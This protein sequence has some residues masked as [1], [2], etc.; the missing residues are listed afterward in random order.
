MRVAYLWSLIVVLALAGCGGDTPSTDAA[1][2]EG[3]DEDLTR[4]WGPDVMPDKD[5]E[6]LQFLYW[7]VDQWFERE[8]LDHDGRLSMDEYK[9]QAQ[10]FE[11]IDA[12]GDGF[13]TKQEVLDDEIPRMRE[14]GEIP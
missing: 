1:P 4:R 14:R 7:R 5:A 12:D 10:N 2:A 3:V 6:P 8:D 9:G 13:I 11:R